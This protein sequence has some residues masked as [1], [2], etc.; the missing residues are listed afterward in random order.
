MSYASGFMMGT[1]IVQGIGQLLSGMDA[2]KGMG[3]VGRGMRQGQGRGFSLDSSGDIFSLPRPQSARMTANAAAFELVSSLP[4]RRRYRMGGM[5]EQQARIFEDTLRR[6]PYMKE[7]AANAISGSLL[8]IYDASRESQMDEIAAVLKRYIQ[9]SSLPS[10]QRAS[11]GQSCV[12]VV[13]PPAETPIGD[14]TRVIRRTMQDFSLWIQ[15]NTHGFFDANSLISAVFF[16]QGIRK[17]LLTQ[18]FPSGSQMLWWAVSLMRG[19]RSA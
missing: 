14:L 13:F 9:K 4:G 6:L 10:P 7:V 11:V 5:T 2:P 1:A 3:G 8:L 19:W 12:P 15:R 17:L 16:I 18:Q